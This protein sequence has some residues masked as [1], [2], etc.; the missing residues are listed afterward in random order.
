MSSSPLT[1]DVELQSP[2][3]VPPSPSTAQSPI[4]AGCGHLPNSPT[5]PSSTINPFPSVELC[6]PCKHREDISLAAH[7]WKCVHSELP[8]GGIAEDQIQCNTWR[9]TRLALANY[10]FQEDSTDG[11]GEEEDEEPRWCEIYRQVSEDLDPDV[12]TEEEM[13][14]ERQLA[15]LRARAA[16]AAAARNKRKKRKSAHVV[17]GEDDEPT[18][19][20]QLSTV[21]VNSIVGLPTPESTEGIDTAD[22]TTTTTTVATLATPPRP[23]ISVLKTPTTTT[24]RGTNVSTSFDLNSDIVSI[25]PTHLTNKKQIRNVTFHP[26]AAVQDSPTP[27]PYPHRPETEYRDQDYYHREKNGLRGWAYEPG[28]WAMQTPASGLASDGTAPLD[29]GKKRQREKDD[30]GDEKGEGSGDWQYKGPVLT[31]EEVDRLGR[32]RRLRSSR[33]S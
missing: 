9:H 26:T 25:F 24:T 1:S 30:D 10:L 18:F 11:C 12:L 14:D 5:T 4:E 27:F 28:Q 3:A 15:A 29:K 13:E 17:A 31:P 33:R 21:R 6:K 16:C 20:G 32:G 8:L 19:E 22:P 23:L 2:V 7:L